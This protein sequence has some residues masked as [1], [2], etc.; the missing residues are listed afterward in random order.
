MTQAVTYTIERV[1][2]ST[3]LPKERSSVSFRKYERSDTETRYDLCAPIRVRWSTVFFFFF[4][5]DAIWHRGGDRS[6]SKAT[7]RSAHTRASLAVI[8][9]ACTIPGRAKRPGSPCQRSL[10][11]EVC[12]RGNGASLQT[13]SMV[14]KVRGLRICAILLSH[15]PF[16]PLDSRLPHIRLRDHS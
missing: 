14:Q 3:G 4:C 9:G 2:A 12:L 16:S 13:P 5:G 11:D 10:G 8:E 1:N 15:F 6:S 7:H